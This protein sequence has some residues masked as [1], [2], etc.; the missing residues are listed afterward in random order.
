MIRV[1]FE[2]IGGAGWMGGRTYLW[3]LLWAVSGLADRRLQCVLLSPEPDAELDHLRNVER[4][5]VPAVHTRPQR[6]VHLALRY[7]WGRDLLRERMLGRARVDV[8]S[9]AEP[10]GRRSPIPVISWITDLQH[11][12]RPDWFSL[13]ER[14]LRDLMMQQMVRHSTRI[15]L[16]SHAALADLKRFFGNDVEPKCRVLQFVSQPRVP[17]SASLPRPSAYAL[18]G[19]YFHLPNQFWRHKNHAVVVEALRLARA[20]EPGMQVVATGPAEDYRHPRHYE[21]LMA[22]VARLGLERQFRHIGVVPYVDMIALMK[23]A[24]AVINPS[25]FEGWSSTIEE[26]KSLG[27]TILLS[28]LEVHREQQPER[29]RFFLPDD[30][31]ALARLMVEVWRSHDAA[32]DQRAAARAAAL[33]PARTEAFGATYQRIVLDALG[34]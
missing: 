32:D 3:N 10:L 9:H 12:R 21:E 7:G 30:A 18:Q 28:E 34:A 5:R 13:R 23:H 26:A 11:R 6:L 2:P 24:V 17:A 14:L 25:H 19:P 33:L 4:V 29:G 1:G 15:V 20:E 22:R 16:S 31:E 27:K 8:V